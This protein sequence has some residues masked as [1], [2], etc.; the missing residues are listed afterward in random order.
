MVGL[1]WAD[2]KWWV[3][4]PPLWETLCGLDLLGFLVFCAVRVLLFEMLAVEFGFSVE[5]EA[6]RVALPVM[7]V[8]G[9]LG[10]LRLQCLYRG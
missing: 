5:Q 6:V 3:L 4:A 10:R 8:K 2:L 1:E 7:A 9:R